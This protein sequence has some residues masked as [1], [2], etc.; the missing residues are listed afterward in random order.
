MAIWGIKA[1]R[2]DN[3]MRVIV[4]LHAGVCNLAYHFQFA[5]CTKSLIQTSRVGTDRI[6]IGRRI[7]LNRQAG[8]YY[9]VSYNG[10]QIVIQM[11]IPRHFPSISPNSPRHNI[12]AF[13]ARVSFA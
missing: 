10:N 12:T 4:V 5:A 7:N 9:R 8:G 2:R 11:Q 3:A 13:N 1:K 6:L